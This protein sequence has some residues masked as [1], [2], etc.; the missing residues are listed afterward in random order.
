MDVVHAL[1]ALR[2]EG[3]GR[4]LS[5]A[6]G[7]GTEITPYLAQHSV[8]FDEVNGNSEF[9]TGGVK[10]VANVYWDDRAYRYSG[11]ASK[12]LDGIRKF[13]YVEWSNMKA[14]FVKFPNNL[15]P[16]EAL[17][18]LRAKSDPT[19]NSRPVPHVLVQCAEVFYVN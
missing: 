5:T 1:Q 2:K 4:S 15:A 19:M 18:L 3:S 17:G 11:D 7:Q 8:P 6:A 16:L 9:Q 14:E 13:R 10:P 12:D